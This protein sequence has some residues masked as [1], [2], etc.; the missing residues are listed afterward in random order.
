MTDEYLAAMKTIAEGH[1]WTVTAPQRVIQGPI[2]RANLSSPVLAIRFT[3]GQEPG[4]DD[5]LA[6]S[7]AVETV[8]WV[9]GVVPSM[10]DPEPAYLACLAARD[11]MRDLV[12]ANRDW[13]LALVEDTHPISSSLEDATIYDLSTGQPQG[14]LMMMRL[15]MEVRF[16]AGD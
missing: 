8:E 11:E 7:M 6:A 12:I 5:T 4:T 13:G 16:Y 10:S 9:Y 3:G 1:S 15:A 2:P 14:L